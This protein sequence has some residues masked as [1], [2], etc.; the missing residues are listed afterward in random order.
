MIDEVNSQ[1]YKDW[2]E[3][4]QGLDQLKKFQDQWKASDKKIEDIWKSYR[5]LPLQPAYLIASHYQYEEGG[6]SLK[7][8]WN[9]YVQF[10]KALHNNK[11]PGKISSS[12]ASALETQQKIVVLQQMLAALEDK[13]KTLQDKVCAY[14]DLKKDYPQLYQDI[15]HK[16]E[17]AKGRS[18]SQE[19]IEVE[20]SRQ[21]DGCSK[22][23]IKKMLY[24]YREGY[25]RLGDHFFKDL[26]NKK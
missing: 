9:L 23:V 10:D 1:E 13:S 20:I 7:T 17:I 25:P 26:L 11:S 19:E 4:V 18:T 12:I 8:K 22:A 2:N 14:K 16:I 24:L 15:L 6:W 5:L 21:P 3:A